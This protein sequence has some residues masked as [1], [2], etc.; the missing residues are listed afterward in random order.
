[1]R[2]RDCLASMNVTCVD[3]L[4]SM[5]RRSVALVCR[6]LDTTQAINFK[7]SL[8][9]LDPFR[10]TTKSMPSAAAMQHSSQHYNKKCIQHRSGGGIAIDD[11]YKTIC[12]HHYHF[13]SLNENEEIDE[14]KR[15][16]G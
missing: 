13:H 5:S 6:H 11:R 7:L 15:K 14:G 12:C 3:D 9:L 16:P 2:L 1:M 8:G 4:L 10:Q